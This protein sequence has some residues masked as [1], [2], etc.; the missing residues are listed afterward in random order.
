MTESQLIR[1]VD[2]SVLLGVT[3]VTVHRMMASG[4]LP[5]VATIYGRVIPREAVLKLAEARAIVAG[6]G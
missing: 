6:K 2:A 4:R 1:P 3:R 5:S